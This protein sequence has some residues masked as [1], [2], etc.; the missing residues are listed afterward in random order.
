M[1]TSKRAPGEFNVN[2][3]VLIAR[4]KNPGT[5]HNQYVWVLFCARR[6]DN[7][8]L[9]GNLYGANGS[10]FHLRKCPSCQ[11]GAAG[12]GFDKLT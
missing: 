3:Q 5:D 1:T 6:L 10:D 7:G 11:S 9:C 4:T 12:L 8:N 2:D